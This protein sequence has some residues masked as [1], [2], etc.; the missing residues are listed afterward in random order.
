MIR[1]IKNKDGSVRYEARVKIGRKPVYRRFDAKREA[2]AWVNHLRFRRDNRQSVTTGKVTVDDLYQG[3]VT[4]AENKGRAPRTLHRAEE[5]FRL[6]VKPF[7][8]DFDMQTVTVEEHEKFLGHLKRNT[9]LSNATIN[10]IRSLM[11]VMFNVSK[12]KGLFGGS[13]TQNPFD[14]VESLP[15]H[16]KPVKY[17]SREEVEKLL[18]CERE[19]FFY[20]LWVT[21]LHTGLRVGELMA[22]DRCQIDTDAHIITVD[23]T[24][25]DR[26]HMIKMV[27]KGKKIRH[28]G[29]NSKVQEILYP[30][31]KDGFV[32]AH[33][34]GNPLTHTWIYH[35]LLPGACKG[36][37]IS[38]I[39]PHGIRHTFA[40][41]YMMEG[42]NLWDLQKILGHSDIQTTENYYAHFSREHV[43]RRANI[44][45]F[46]SKVIEV[47]FKQ[48]VV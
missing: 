16:L 38:M 41:H 33:E 45:S 18:T 3:Y 25:C 48:G 40:A 17:W 34:N 29:I 42:G 2:E 21:W 31:L 47:D 32:F 11:T 10:R 20:P 9:K 35:Y 19:S 46:G 30:I 39:N 15:E 43:L 7:Y 14:R 1:K 44:L 36:A 22:L 8:Q 5:F 23:R 6:Y 26:T 24:K 28:V 27:T 12:K 13:I 4:F 37:K